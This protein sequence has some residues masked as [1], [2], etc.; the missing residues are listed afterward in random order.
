MGECVKAFLGGGSNVTLMW[1]DIKYNSGRLV[2]CTTPSLQ[3]PGILYTSFTAVFRYFCALSLNCR[4]VSS[5]L[6]VGSKLPSLL[7][8]Q[9][10][11][12]C[13]NS[14]KWLRYTSVHRHHHRMRGE[15]VKLSEFI[16]YEV[17]C[18][19]NMIHYYSGTYFSTLVHTSFHKLH[20]S[21]SKVQYFLS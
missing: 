9:V 20:S 2:R 5:D 4:V 15:C 12:A 6:P 14:T 11:R 19:T 10:H 18:Y 21:F 1:T 3:Y 13:C 7:P 8:F 17:L 16:S